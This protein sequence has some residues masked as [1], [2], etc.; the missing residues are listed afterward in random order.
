M[1][2]GVTVG[3]EVIV[4]TGESDGVN[5]SVAVTVTVRDAVGV[6]LLVDESV[7]GDMVEVGVPEVVAGVEGVDAGVPVKPNAVFPPLLHD[8]V[9]RPPKPGAPSGSMYVFVVALAATIC[10]STP[11]TLATVLLTR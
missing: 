7:A 10:P 5:D 3:E 2:R 11:D 4:E 8:K 1:G 6:L 9:T